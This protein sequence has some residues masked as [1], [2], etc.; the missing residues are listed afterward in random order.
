MNKG[1]SLT[2]Y[3]IVFICFFL[4]SFIP[5]QKAIA[6][7]GNAV[8]N[9][10][11]PRHETLTQRQVSVLFDQNIL[12]ATIPGWTV[13]VNAIS[14]TINSVTVLGNRVNINFDATPAHAAQNFL[15]PGDVVRVSYSQAAGN[16]LTATAGNPE[17]NSFALS[18]SKNRWIGNC[19]DFAFF[20]I[21][22][23][24]APDIC[25]PVINN[26]RQFQYFLSLRLR[27]SAVFN[28]ATQMRYQINW[29][30]GSALQNVAPY[31][32][33]NAGTANAAFFTTV[34]GFP[35]V[36][37]TSRQIHNFP[38]NTNVCSF[39]LRIFPYIDGVLNC[40]IGSLLQTSTF[41]SYDMDDQNTGI[42]SMIPSVANSNLVCLGNNANMRFSDATTLNCVPDVPNIGAPNVQA[43][44]IRIVYGFQNAVAP[45][46]IP[47]IRVNGPLTGGAQ[48][49]TNGAGVISPVGGYFPIGGGGVGVPDANGVIELATPVNVSTATTFMQTI[50]TSSPVGQVV[51]QRFWVRLDYWNTCNPYN[52][53]DLTNRVSTTNSVEI[54][55]SPNP[56][57]V[58]NPTLC[59]NAANGSF[60]ITA[61]GV[62]AGALTYTWYL[63]AGLTTVLQATNADN[64][65]NP[66][67]EGPVGNRINKNVAVSTTFNR[68]VTVTQGSNNCTSQPQTITIRIDAL[69]TA[70]TIAHPLGATPFT[71][72][73]GTDPAAFTS[74]DNG[75]GGGPGGAITYQWQQSPT[76]G[77]VGFVAAA[78][79]NNLVTYD[80]P[81]LV[82]RTF[83]RRR[84]QSGQ[85][86]DVF[87]NEIEFRI[88]T[89][90]IGGTVGSNQTIC[91]APGDPANL[92]NIASPTGGSNTGT[93]N[94]QWEESTISVVGPFNTIAGATLNTYNP[95]A[96]VTTTTHYRRRVNSGVCAVDGP[97]AGTDPDNIAYSNVITI[98]VDQIVVPGSIGNPQSICSGQDPAVL[99]QIA[100]PSGGNGS[101]YTFLWQESATG[102]GVGFAA[103]PGA[104]TG[105]TYDPPVLVATRFYR[106]Q[107]TSGVCSPTFSNEIQ[108]TVNAL[109]TVVLSGGGSICSGNPAPDVV[110]T[111]TGAGPWDLVYS[112]N[113]VN[114]P[115][116]N[117][118][119]SPFTLAN[120]AA[121]VYAVVSINDNNTPN[122][123]V[124]APNANITGGA[125]VTIQAIPPPTVET[126][127]ATAA[128]CDDGGAT[129]PPD[130]IL[131]LLP[132]SAQFYDITYT[133][134]GNT[135]T[136]LNKSSDASGQ[137]TIQP[138]YTAW[139]SVP[140]SYVVT[141]TA[142]KN[143][144]TLCAGAVPFNSAPLVVN[145]RPALP[146]GPV[147]GIACSVPGTGVP[148]S[149]TDP[150]VG[151]EIE[152]S[153]AG[154][155]LASFAAAVP[156][157][158]AESGTNNR[159]FTPTTSATA[160]FFAFTR[161]TTTGCFSSTGRA[162]TQTQDLR[163]TA[164]AAGPDQPLLCATSATLAATAVN[165]G[166]TGTWSVVGPVGT[167]VIT[168]PNS[169]NS[170]VTGLPQDVPGGLPINTT[171]RWTAT[172]ALS[173][174]SPT[175]DDVIL[176]VNP[177]PAVTN[178]TPQLCEDVSGGGSRA[179]FDLTTLNSSVTGGAAGVTVEWFA[180]PIPASPILPA[181]TPQNITN[182]AGGTYFVRLTSTAG[183]Q[184]TGTVTFTVNSLPAAVDRNF[185]FC[186]NTVGAGL[187][188]NFA[189]NTINLTTFEFGAGG[190]T[191]GGTAV[192]RDVEWYEDAA[193]TTL[194]APGA[195]VGQ[196][197]NYT[198]TA[199]K[200]I[201][202]KVI[203][204]TS[205]VTPRCFDVADV[206][207]TLKLRPADNPIT[208]GA[209]VCT[210]STIVLYQV[211]PGLN[212]GSNYTWSVTSAVADFQVFGGGGINSPNFFILLK[213]PGPAIGN[214]DISVFETL[215]GCTGNTSNFT[216]TVAGAP[217]ALTFNSPQTNVCNN[218]TGVVY[219]L[220]APNPLSLYT[221]TAPGA[222]FQGP[223]SG[224]GLS[225]VT[226]DFTTITPVTISVTE[227]SSS[228]CAGSPAAVVVNLVDRPVMSSSNTT[229]VCSGSAPALAFAATLSGLPTASVTFGWQVINIS[230]SVS[231]TTVG[232]TG[233]GNLSELLT[234]TSGVIGTVTY[235][236]TPTETVVPNPP[237]CTGTPQDVV[238]TVNPEPV[239][240]TPQTKTICSNQPVN[241]Q[242][243]LN[244]ATLPVGTVF[245]W[246][247][248]TMSNASVQ[249]SPGVNVAVG[250]TPH[251]TDVLVNLTTAPITATYM[252]TPSNGSCSGTPQSVV[253]TVNPQPV[254][255][256]D[257]KTICSNTTVSY[258]LQAT[259]IDVLGNSLPSTFSWIAASNPSVTGESTSAQNTAI[260]NDNLRNVTNL[261]QLVVYTITPTGANG[262]A[263][264]PFTV[265]I[266]VKPE[267][268]GVADTK[269]I[270]SNAVVN[271]D[272]QVSNINTLGN[273]LASTFSWVAA[274][275]ANV[276]GESTSPQPGATINDLL[277]NTTSV[278]QTVTYTVTP[279]SSVGICT[280]STFIITLTVQPQP[281]GVN[282][283][284]NTCSDVVLSYSLQ[285]NINTL[286]N[287]IVSTFS[288]VAAANGNV[289][290]ESTIPKVTGTINDVLNNVTGSD[291]VVV[292]TVTPTSG[293]GCAG[294]P[295]TV[296]VTVKSEP[297][298]A[299][300]VKTICSDAS[301]GY[302]LQVTNLDILGNSQP[303]S[304]SWV[305]ASN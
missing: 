205:P 114:Q 281:V 137:L 170:T 206:T 97:D 142:L 267:P 94:F 292:Y 25:S 302:N 125:T 22:D 13:T 79:V 275:T 215:N 228:G 184:N 225:S 255:A 116:V 136:E 241:H 160:T 111:F 76:G 16:T 243:L 155:A 252:I 88:D 294:N 233:T 167:I 84:I 289:S 169:F 23:Y 20:Q 181:T 90:V 62:G 210:G 139:G 305:A 21:G 138:P 208:G 176:T 230:G 199:T 143:T 237:N 129:N 282:D 245:N 248:P 1:S 75:T 107:V 5:I 268:V 303:S 287:A 135:F 159:T 18:L 203:D 31:L 152:W 77:G 284:T 295:F 144:L 258:N 286:G 261:D 256:A 153:T 81:A 118:T 33:D 276:S 297:L 182:G 128:V 100:A 150:G 48:N 41:I 119:T 99:T 56:P 213:F 299:A 130:A 96:G 291:Q 211:N 131:D 27:N 280:G 127:T 250:A 74:P 64:T 101:T 39:N 247:L 28:Y 113:G 293:N 24:A 17:V 145:P 279:T 285:N 120:P 257:T 134:N 277:I 9:A 148:L 165:N 212:P 34:P 55:G 221:W 179:N 117:N 196:E 239:L 227:T 140:G 164:A 249:G 15:I 259:N 190:V 30:D 2:V 251:I 83:F 146:A 236:V 290:G 172:S 112:I 217:G 271:Y 93:Y 183:C 26:F 154:P 35:A 263:G 38:D 177:L 188:G 126:F 283:V 269:T 104:N 49:I 246:G 253:I 209:T 151:F 272:L 180:D 47:N 45:G 304:F 115:V 265:S 66:V 296:S 52:P 80:P 73:S 59:E 231:G 102:G 14:V 219:S 173:V 214:V 72:C 57:A 191:N 109:P 235:R 103:A 193:L 68:F 178:L 270:C 4:L 58:N 220:N 69:N 161:N 204:L 11:D 158:G 8:I 260:I 32:S 157:S 46:N 105:A 298:G 53:G 85:C 226:L 254:G 54:I 133:V 3:K 186:E 222:S 37:T 197:Q 122:C 234:N 78:G 242:I 163:P 266:T 229:S 274:S 67:T 171:L 124:T 42:L 29:G 278:N 12:S 207:L 273:G 7:A 300:D 98:T 50:T 288:W 108:V 86:A 63:D 92:T 195:G 175:Q 168:S 61:T 187:A 91:E 6:Q 121:G 201:F 71:L 218:Q 60:N 224:V 106:R 232:N 202:A 194:I 216:V 70:G 87:S 149:V 89:P 147:N 40:N 36:V 110:F 43:R 240:V 65:F 51:G 95:P 262:C 123:L 132:N 301:V 264:S 238:V 156:G 192:T 82:A 166:G 200:T 44:W 189:G 174:C 141:V 185:Q 198:I 223:S 19:T 244:P 162:V 10:T